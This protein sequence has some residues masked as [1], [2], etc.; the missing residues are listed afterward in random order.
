MH[1]WDAKQY[2]RFADERTQPAL[3][4]LARIDLAAPRHIVDLGCGPGNST[5]PPR[6]RRPPLDR[7]SRLRSRQQPE[8]SARSRARRGD[9]GARQLARHAGGGTA[10]EIDD[11]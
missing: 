7:R 8:L 2:L 10:A 4:L 6:A 11:M 9:H 1:G 3:D 5:R